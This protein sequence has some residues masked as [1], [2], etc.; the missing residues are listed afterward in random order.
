MHQKCLLHRGQN[1]AL[2]ETLDGRDLVTFCGGGKQKTAVHAPAV[3]QNRARSALP[4]VATLLCSRQVQ[5]LTQSIKQAGPRIQFEAVVRTI[6][7]ERYVV[8]NRL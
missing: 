1:F 6:N 2:R 3:N 4:V 5:R 8:H 7:L